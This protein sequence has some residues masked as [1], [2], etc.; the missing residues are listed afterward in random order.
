M[1]KRAKQ[2][3]RANQWQHCFARFA[4]LSWIQIMG[5]DSAKTKLVE[6]RLLIPPLHE[7]YIIHFQGLNIVLYIFTSH[8]AAY[9]VPVQ[10]ETYSRLGCIS[11]NSQQFLLQYH[12]NFLE[13]LQLLVSMRF[14]P[15]NEKFFLAIN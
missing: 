14:L 15:C 4:R 8:K 12:H 9:Q 5:D 10:L 6:D 13:L 2:C 1:Y 3:K 7:W 11:F